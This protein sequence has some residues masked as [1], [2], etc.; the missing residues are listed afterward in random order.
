MWPVYEVINMMK[1]TTS[2]PFAAQ[3]TTGSYKYTAK[4]PNMPNIYGW[5]LNTE[6]EAGGPK[7]LDCQSESS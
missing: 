3:K 6:V 7:T 4:L 2:V 1:T 5:M